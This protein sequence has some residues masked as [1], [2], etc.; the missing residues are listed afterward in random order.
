MHPKRWLPRTGPYVRQG[1]SSLPFGKVPSALDQLC[2][3]PSGWDVGGTGL[4]WFTVA[5]VANYQGFCDFKHQVFITALQVRSLGR[6]HQAKIRQQQVT[7]L[8]GS[9]GEDPSRLTQGVG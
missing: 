7:F 1:G 3:G 2:V 9:P 8:V 6:C 4:H 5:V